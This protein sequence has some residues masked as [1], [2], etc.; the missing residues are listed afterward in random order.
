[1]TEELIKEKC[2]SCKT[3]IMNII[4]STKFQC[5]K[6]GKTTII[7]CKHC[8]KLAT[9]YKCENCGFEGPN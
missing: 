7:R 4:G 8:R 2:S 5:P 9:K 3:M 1:M 6:C